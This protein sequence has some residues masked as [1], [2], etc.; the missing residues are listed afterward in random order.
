MRRRRRRLASIQRIA[1][2]LFAWLGTTAASIAAGLEPLAGLESGA[3]P[4]SATGPG[5]IPD[6]ALAWWRFDPTGFRA[7]D[8]AGAE[9]VAI[10]G[11]LRALVSGRLIESE[12]TSRVVEGILAAGEVGAGPHTLCVLDFQADRDADGGMDPQRLQMV[13]DLRARDDHRRYLRTIKAILVDAEKAARDQFSGR[14]RRLELP[15]GISG[16]S[17]S[18]TG[19]PRWRTV[20]WTSTDSSFLIGLGEGSLSRWLGARTPRG[21]DAGT[22]P[23]RGDPPWRA[24]ERQVDDQRP[25]GDEFFHAYLDIDALRDGFPGAFAAGR[26]I[27]AFDALDL[28]N[29]RCVMLHG[30]RIQVDDGLPPLLA[31]DITWESRSEPPGTVRRMAI[32]EDAWPADAISLDP[33]PGSYLLVLR[34]DWEGWLMR[35][36]DLNLAMTR[37]AD[38]DEKRRATTRWLGRS[39]RLLAALFAKLEPWVIISDAPAPVIPIPGAATFFVPLDPRTQID[40]ATRQLNA[41]LGDWS[42]RIGEAP[43]GVR[44][45]R[46]D[47]AGAIRAPAWGFIETDGA[48]VFVGGWGPPVVIENR[49]RLAPRNE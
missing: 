11:L 1:P 47:P 10:A 3:R 9:R 34:A 49:R 2:I 17:F 27:R 35:A 15:G 39:N 41:L 25:D 32:S 24:H 45:L 38:L 7:A 16:V 26:A 22:N 46:L 31:L 44:W 21:D 28:S 4:E 40:L 33:P 19:W 5:T 8:A 18:E 20:S 14:Q 30:R 37:D 42:D 29:A 23:D 6:G 12:G 36:L 43:P 48:G 13:L